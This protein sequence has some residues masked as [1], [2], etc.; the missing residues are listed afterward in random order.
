MEKEKERAKEEVYS[1]DGDSK[2]EFVLAVDDLESVVSFRPNAEK[3]TYKIGESVES[4][5]DY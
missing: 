2:V 1:S 3:F 4:R 5:K